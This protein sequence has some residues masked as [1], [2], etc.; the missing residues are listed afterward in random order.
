M[1]Q[2]K[3]TEKEIETVM[4]ALSGS[5]VVTTSEFADKIEQILRLHTIDKNNKL[6]N[7]KLD[8]IVGQ[9]SVTYN[10]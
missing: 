8:D 7:D 5:P 9:L 6:F 10:R 4:N 1:E 2:L 3:L